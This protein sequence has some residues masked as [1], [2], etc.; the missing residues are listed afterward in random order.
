MIILIT[1]ISLL[2]LFLYIQ[3]HDTQSDERIIDQNTIPVR[4][5]V[6]TESH[7]KVGEPFEH[8]KPLPDGSASSSASD[9]DPHNCA[10]KVSF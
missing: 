8:A 4:Q 2:G 3:R 5:R 1:V 10:Y 7:A 9:S 6:I